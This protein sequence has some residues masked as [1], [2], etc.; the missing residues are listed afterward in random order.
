M[1]ASPAK[2]LFEHEEQALTYAAYRIGFGTNHAVKADSEI[3]KVCQGTL[4]HDKLNEVAALLSLNIKNHGVHTRTEEAFAKFSSVEELRV[5]AILLGQGSL[6]TKLELLYE[7]FTRGQIETA[8][9]HALL[10]TVSKVCLDILGHL[11]D[12][13]Q[14]QRSGRLR[15]DHYISL[16]KQAEERWVQSMMDSFTTPNSK[17]NFVKVFSQ[18]EELSSPQCFRRHCFLFAKANPLGALSK[19]STTSAFSRLRA[20]ANQGGEGRQPVEPTSKA[21]VALL[22]QEVQMVPRSAV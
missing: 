12:D 22:S 17:D 19:T 20:T 15:N 3:L 13:G 16:C 1:G 7:V 5:A 4:T 9:L 18:R 8:H 21:H 14:G 10:K 6:S 11:V 2:N